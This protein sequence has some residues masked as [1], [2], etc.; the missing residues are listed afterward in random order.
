MLPAAEIKRLQRLRDDDRFRRNEGVF[1][2]EGDKSV[3]EFVESARFRG[4]LFVMPEWAG[5]KRERGVSD[6]AFAAHEV[7]AAEMARISHLPSPGSVLAVLVRPAFAPLDPAAL[8]TGFTLALDAVQDPGNVGTIIRI[9]DWYGFDR[10]LLG[11]GCA[12]PFSQKVV[13]A[14]KGSLARAELHRVELPAVLGSA[15]V[16]VLGCDLDGADLHRLVAPPAAI[17]VIG[18]EGRGLS[19][20]V[21]AT[22]TQRVTIPAFGRAESLNAAVAAAIVCDNL[23]RLS[24]AG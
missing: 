8:R 23:R 11:E 13:N 2:V 3:R 14:S 21:R 20:P 12:D 5:W 4:D 10:V 16:P 15:G 22:L 19:A 18:S 9:A 6:G 7:T 24:G 1:I 17:V